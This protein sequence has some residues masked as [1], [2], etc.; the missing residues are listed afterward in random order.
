MYVYILKCN[1]SRYYI[2]V[3]NNLERRILEHQS[4]INPNCFTYKRRPVELVFFEKFTTPTDA[5][6]FEKKLKGWSTA[7]KEA[8]I[9]SN[10][11]RLH[12]LAKCKNTTSHELHKASLDS[13]RD[14]KKG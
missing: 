4:G 6:V 8:L 13:A 2:G 7:K 5:I 9:T 11:E 1:D 10:W 3:T 12:E 14:D